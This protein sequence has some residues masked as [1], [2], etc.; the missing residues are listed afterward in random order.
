MENDSATELNHPQITKTTEQNPNNEVNKEDI[1]KLKAIKKIM[2]TSTNQMNLYSP[3]NH[4]NHHVI[5][6]RDYHHHYHHKTTKNN[7]NLTNPLSQ[8]EDE[9]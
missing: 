7:H 6:I 8:F 2:V 5:T 3:H 4:I 1:C 9:L